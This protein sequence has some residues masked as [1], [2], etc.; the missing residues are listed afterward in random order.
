MT[1]NNKYMS[2]DDFRNLRGKE[3]CQNKCKQNAQVTVREPQEGTE[4]K[5]FDGIFVNENK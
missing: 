3:I 1:R 2:K 4:R 5:N